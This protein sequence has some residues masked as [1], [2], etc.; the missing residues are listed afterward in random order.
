MKSIEDTWVQ[1]LVPFPKTGH[2]GG[3]SSSEGSMTV[4]LVMLPRD[5]EK[6]KNGRREGAEVEGPK[7]GGLGVST[8]PWITDNCHD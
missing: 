1:G 2:T 3:E 8:P 4:G 6:E 5:R 7:P